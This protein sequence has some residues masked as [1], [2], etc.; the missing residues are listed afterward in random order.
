MNKSVNEIGA[1]AKQAANILGKATT[2][3]KNKVLERIAEELL[4]FKKSILEAN[5]RDYDTAQ[6]NG[7][8]EALLDRLSLQGRIESMASD[9]HHITELDDPIGEVLENNTLPNQLQISKQRT[10]IGVIGV[11]YESRPNVT[12]DV[13]AL[14]IKSGNC[15][16]LRGGSDTIETNQ[17][18][19]NI[20]QKALIESELPADCVQLIV[21][22]DRARVL[23]LLQMHAFVDMIIPR[24]GASL[25]KFCRE[26]SQIPVITGGIGVCHLYVDESADIDRAIEVIYNAKMQRPTVCNALD[27]IL[28]KESIADKVIPKVIQKLNGVK[29]HLDEKSWKFHQESCIPVKEDDW[30][31]EWLSLDLG[32]KIV[33]DLDEAIQHI[34][35]HSTGHSDGILTENKTLAEKFIRE[36]NSACVYVNAST[37]FTDGGQF[38]LGAE[39][40]VSTQKLHARGPMGLKELTSYKWIVIGDYHVRS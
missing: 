22:P 17:S 8:D 31:K 32:I 21:D 26:N 5:K 25:H 38:G 16:I 35:K 9:V 20:I 10:P 18:L 2:A 1:S 37:R 15:V 3:Q 7:M 39:V 33:K 13:S 11:V 40:A 23:D 19:V 24:G 36:I 14:A 29:F 6:K 34:Q 30:D 27:T 12:I 28:V 4:T